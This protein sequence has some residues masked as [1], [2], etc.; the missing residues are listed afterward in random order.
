[1]RLD[2]STQIISV[3]GAEIIFFVAHDADLSVNYLVNG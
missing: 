1:M 2:I 3:L